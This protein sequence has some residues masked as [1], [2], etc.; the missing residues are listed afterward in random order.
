V[1]VGLRAKEKKPKKAS[2]ILHEVRGFT[3]KNIQKAVFSVIENPFF[4]IFFFRR[5]AFV[6]WAAL[7]RLFLRREITINARA[8]C[9]ARGLVGLCVYYK[10]TPKGVLQFFFYSRLNAKF[11]V[12]VTTRWCVQHSSSGTAEYNLEQL[13]EKELCVGG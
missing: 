9:L 8:F 10:S 12:L 2:K 5:A 3:Y 4:R 13:S 6:R 7:L 11:W 1:C